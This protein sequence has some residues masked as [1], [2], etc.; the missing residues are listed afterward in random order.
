M[1]FSTFVDGINWRRQSWM[2]DIHQ[3]IS[4]L[5]ITQL[6]MVG[7]HNSGTFDISKTSPYGPDTLG[8]LQKYEAAGAFSRF[9]LGSTMARWGQ[10]QGASIADQLRFG[11]RYFDLRLAPHP[12]RHTELFTTHGFLSTPLSE[13]LQDILAFLELEDVSHEIILLDFQHLFFDGEDA[14]YYQLL[15]SLA[16][17]KDKCV[18]FTENWFSRT[19]DDIWK[20]EQRIFVFIN[21]VDGAPPHPFRYP[22]DQCIFSSWKNRRN[23][24]GLLSEFQRDVTSSKD[25]DISKVY[26]TQAILTPNTDSIV[27]GFF[28]FAKFRT[29]RRMAQEGNKQLVEWFCVHSI[30]SLKDNNTHRNVLMLDFPETSTALLSL[31]STSFD[32][33]VVDICVVANLFRF[34]RHSNSSASK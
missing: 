17:L 11:I 8:L 2:S 33:T 29:V 32:G 12:K 13:V 25:H 31:D 18:P 21:P 3:F 26:V 7:T 10:C 5:S 22:R 19:L 14:L 24:R 20:S 23:T 15:D 27:K 16:V 1:E 28:P 6:V 34:W 4:E 30:A 9:L